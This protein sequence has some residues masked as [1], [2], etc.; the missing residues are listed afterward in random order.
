MADES[1]L[2]N[3]SA[4]GSSYPNLV[5]YGR[6]ILNTL[7]AFI[8]WSFEKG[9]ILFFLSHWP[10]KCFASSWNDSLWS[11]IPS[12]SMI[13][14]AFLDTS[15]SISNNKII[16]DLYRKPTERNQYLLPSS[17]HPAHVTNNIP[18]SLAY[19]IVRICSDQD[20]RDKRL[21]ELSKLLLDRNYKKSIINAANNKAK[22]IVSASYC[23]EPA[24]FLQQVKGRVHR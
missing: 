8:L 15:C 24:I 3:V 14:N 1:W 19:R 10:Q 9:F 21:E 22:S 6:E 16:L 18:F 2:Q 7:W 11:P 23:S 12:F 20:T 4:K 17:C 13:W 5:W